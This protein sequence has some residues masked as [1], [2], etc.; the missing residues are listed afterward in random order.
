MSVLFVVVILARE[1]VLDRY[2][3]NLIYSKL[4]FYLTLSK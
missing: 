3:V 4:K 1:V 2:L